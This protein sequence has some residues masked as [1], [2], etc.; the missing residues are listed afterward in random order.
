MNSDDVIFYSSLLLCVSLANYYKK[1]DDKRLKRNYGTGLGILVACLI[2]GHSILHTVIMVWGNIV[3]I[4]CCDKRY[5]H[6]MSLAYTWLYLS[7]LHWSLQKNCYIIWLHQTLALRLVGLAFEI[8]TYQRLKVDPGMSTIK[9]NMDN[10]CL[11]T[12]PSAGDIIS[13]AFYFTGIHKGPYYRWKVFDD[14][15]NAPFGTLGDCRI[16]T[17]QKLK[18]AFACSLGYLLLRLKYSPQMYYERAFYIKYGSDFR[19]LYNIPQLTMYFLHYQI[20]MLLCTS[21]CTEAG[22]GVYPAKCLPIPGYGPSTRFSLL[23]LAAR[24]PTIAMEEEYNF[25]MLKCFKNEKL[26]LGPRMKDTIRSWDMPTRFWFWANMYKNFIKAN[27]EIRSACSFV[28]WSIWVGPSIPQ[29]IVSSTL[30]VY[31]HLESEYCELYDTTGSMKIPWNIGFSIMRVF[32]LIYL[33]PCL[34][35]HDTATVLRYYNS[36]YWIYHFFLLFLIVA[37]IVI[38]KLKDSL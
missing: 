38:F 4:K 3:I 12:D 6:Q 35:V 27:K 14:H 19:F 29:I 1:I 25:S 17:E 13:Y 22:F 15:F 16:I 21:V 11:S 28:A 23:K 34:I 7:Y 8:S 26:L 20:V 2:C 36:I 10:E 24:T 5:V 30:W 37:A 18:K 33:A 31:V 9:P 32:C